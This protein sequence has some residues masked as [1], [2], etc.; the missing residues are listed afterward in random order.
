MRVSADRITAAA[1]ARVVRERLRTAA[2]DAAS[3]LLVEVRRKPPGRSGQ[4][5]SLF[6]SRGSWPARERSLW[7]GSG[8]FLLAGLGHG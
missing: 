7:P 2:Q 4:A 8:G 5:S 1:A 3:A 6:G